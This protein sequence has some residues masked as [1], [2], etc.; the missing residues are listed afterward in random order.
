[1]TEVWIVQPYVPKY[2]VPFF[3]QLAAALAVDDITLRVVAG[4]PVGAQRA[5]GDAAAPE[6]LMRSEDRSVTIG[7]RTLTLTSTR[8]FWRQADAVI[9]P[10]MGSSLDVYRALLHRPGTR[11]VGL[12][13]HI[14]SFVGDPHPLDAALERWQLRHADQI[15]AYTPTGAQFAIHVG[16]PPEQVT[17][18]M[19]S[20]DTSTLVADFNVL[21]ETDLREFRARNGI[22]QR[23]IL[24]YLGGL[25]RDKRIGFL[26]ATLDELA[27]VGS[28]VHLIVGGTGSDAHLLED[29]KARGQV[30]ML[31][32]VDGQR[33][34]LLLR[35]ASAVVNPGRIGLLAVETL[36]VGRPILTTE[37]PYHAPE[38]EYLVEG[39]SRYSSGN[40]PEAFAALIAG[41][42][43]V[44]LRS[45]PTE[46]VPTLAQMVTRFSCGVHRLVTT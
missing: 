32:F 4:Q 36:A 13:G 8:R 27:R 22:P 43:P 10:H 35:A 44:P 18:V 46:A 2:R 29:A 16:V 30:T 1:M 17:T 34:A 28:D 23:P 7:N 14:A 33:K 26:A 41:H 3:E 24:A 11:K 6:W 15:F 20:V 5:R 31:G 39:Q 45:I 25:D 9:V 40:T 38:A 21:T 12:W 42:T 19:N 37:W